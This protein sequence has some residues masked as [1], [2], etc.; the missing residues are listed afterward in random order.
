MKRNLH[1]DGDT[2][3]A[4]RALIAQTPAAERRSLIVKWSKPIANKVRLFPRYQSTGQRR[5][6][7]A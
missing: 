2:F 6:R 4:M 7:A 5:W 1:F 3:A